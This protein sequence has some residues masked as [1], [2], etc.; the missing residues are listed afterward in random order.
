LETLGVAPAFKVAS[1]SV[2]NFVVSI[3]VAIIVGQF[4]L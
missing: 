1:P 2:E 4:L 3:T